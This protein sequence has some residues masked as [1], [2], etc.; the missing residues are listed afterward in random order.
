MNVTLR[1]IQAFLA[2]ADLGNF[3]RAAAR[4]N[5]AQPALSLTI[6][7]LEAE[8]GIRLFDRTTRRVELTAAG[9]DFSYAARKLMTISTSHA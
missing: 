4:I 9:A 2:V 8:L 3:T 7:E 6:R 5:M 1:Q